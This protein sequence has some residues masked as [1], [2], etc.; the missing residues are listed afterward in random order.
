MK[1]TIFLIP[2]LVSLSASAVVAQRINGRLITSMYAWQRDDA[3]GAQTTYVLGYQTF[4]FD[5]YQ[6]A[7]SLHAYL[8]GFNDFGS[9][10]S[11]GPELRMYNLYLKASN[12]GNVLD[13][14]LGRQAVYAGVGSGTIDG[15][16][17][18][19]QVAEGKA[20]LVGYA[21]AVPPPY[22]KFAVVENVDKNFMVGGQ[23]IV[24]P[25]EG[26]RLG[27][28]Y[29]NRRIGQPSYFAIR[30]DSVNNA[31][32]T[33]ISPEPYSDQFVGVDASYRGSA[34]F[35]LYGRYDYDLNY[36]WI[37]RGQVFGRVSIT[38]RIALTGEYIYRSPRLPFHSFFS[39]FPRNSVTEVEG[40]V[41]YNLTALWRAFGRLAYVKYISD[42]NRRYT[43]GLAG[44][45]GSVS[46]SGNVGY[47]GKLNSV[48]A[49]FYY[50]LLNRAVVPTLGLSYAEYRLSWSNDIAHTRAAVL[51][52]TVRPWPTFSF[53]LEFQWLNN[54]IVQ[55]DV[56][57]L[58]RMNYW[59]TEQLNLFQ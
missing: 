36:D 34:R 2:L 16:L 31:L 50:P 54:R 26:S 55:S 19:I 41:E 6:N 45:Y 24:S 23:F 38:D 11:G 15:L 18:R 42:N 29:M 59:F 8:Q 7:I 17:S 53:D 35:S 56:R 51:S 49:Q 44:E 22:Q 58:V 1:R 47:A 40:G 13:L 39:L 30:R 14:S 5:I 28:S 12:L 9:L 10:I 52:S 46:Y 20:V 33:F 57:F 3:I 32:S 27:V 48:S 43:A 37:S 25:F 21:G 4:Q